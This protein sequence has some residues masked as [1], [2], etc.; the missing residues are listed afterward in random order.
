MTTL[1]TN[2]AVLLQVREKGLDFVAGKDMNEVP[3]ISS[4][5]LLIKDGRIADYGKMS[6]VPDVRID[7]KINVEGRL[8]FPS[9]C[10]SHTHIVYAGSRENEFVDRI[11]G[12]TYEEIAAKGG[13][14]LNSATVLQGTS[15]KD[16]LE[17]SYK[18]LKEIIALGTGAVEIKS[19]YGLT[20]T[21]ELKMLRVI[22]KLKALSP[23]PIKATFLAAHALPPSYANNRVAYIKEMLD[24]TLPQIENENLADFIDVFCEKGY[25]DVSDMEVVMKKGAAYGLKAKVHVNQF[26]VIGGV[27]SAVKHEAV[28]VDHLELLTENDL[29]HLKTGKTMGVALPG[30]SFFLGIP[31][32]PARKLIDADLPMALATD[33]NPGSAPSGNMNLVVSLACIKMNMTPAEALNAATINGAYAMH[34]HKE[35][36]SITVGKKA[37]LIITKP[38]TTLAS[39]P[40]SFGSNLIEQVWVNGEKLE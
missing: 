8:V 4:A 38:N 36:G 21:A 28:T 15:E 17:Q 24:E 27:G 1:I 16:L 26:N 33:F 32:T 20:P 40:Y 10:D 6:S 12:L 19:G 2:I 5:Y 31:Y 37:N 9:W 11:N 18:R 39:L 22:K 30:C 13:G 14:I 29:T 25:F 23:I 3:S 35:V 7:K 34:L